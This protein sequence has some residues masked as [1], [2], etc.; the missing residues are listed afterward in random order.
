[1]D[2]HNNGVSLEHQLLKEF[3]KFKL[4]STDARRREF[5]DKFL[6]M[7]EP[8]DITYLNEKLDEYKKDFVSLFP[9]ELI[10]KIFNY[11]DWKTLLNCCQVNSHSLIYIT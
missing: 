4:N 7:C 8:S 9:I 2:D 5:I 6:E 11:L 1:M 3:Q 10:E